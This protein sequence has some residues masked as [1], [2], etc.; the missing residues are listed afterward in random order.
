MSERGLSLGPGIEVATPVLQA[1]IGGLAPP[2]LVAA[3]SSAGGLGSLSLTWTDAEGAAKRV[4]AVKA[5]TSAPFAANFVLSFPHASLH[6]AL[7]G[8]VRVITFSWG[9]PGAL[10]KTVHSFGAAAGVQVGSVDGARRALDEGCDFVICQGVE[11]GGHV[12]SSTPLR[13]LLPAV[14]D[15]AGNRP[16]I[17]AGGLADGA[18]IAEVMALGAAAAML[19]TR[20]VASAESYAHDAYKAA[21]VA[22]NAQDTALTACFDGGWPYAP[23]RVLRN[24][25]LEG[26]EAAGCAPVGSRPGEGDVVAQFSGGR[27]VLRYDVAPPNAD[28]EGDVLACCLYAGLGVSRITEVRPAD[29]LVRDLWRD[30]SAL[31]D[32]A[33][34]RRKDLQAP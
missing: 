17:A 27:S 21:L 32:R 13:V 18:D 15:E 25:T 1:A 12:Q 29:S 14:V 33:S 8:G 23:H 26:W 11:A 2:E 10:V 5:L 30:A 19:G 22:S 7:E 3:V 20:F 31:L 34:A 24:S 6:A 28:T 9:R 16:V 4:A